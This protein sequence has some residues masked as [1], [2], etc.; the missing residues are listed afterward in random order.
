LINSR[1]N[2]KHNPES[3]SGLNPKQAQMTKI[4]REIKEQKSKC[5]ITKQNSKMS[6]STSYRF[7]WDREEGK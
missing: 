3:S 2:P 1:E 5:K 4:Q 7:T 6:L